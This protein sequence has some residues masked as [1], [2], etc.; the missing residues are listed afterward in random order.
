MTAQVRRQREE[1][2]ASRAR[3]LTAA[4]EVQAAFAEPGID[5]REVCAELAAELR[6]MA[7]WLGLERVWAAERGDLADPLRAVLRSV[8]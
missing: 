4:D 5:P 2:H 3:I 6:V 8:P 1:V 7:D